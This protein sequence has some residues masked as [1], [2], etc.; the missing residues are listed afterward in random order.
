MPLGFQP[1][2][3]LRSRKTASSRLKTWKRSLRLGLRKNKTLVRFAPRVFKNALAV[4]SFASRGERLY[5][6]CAEGG[7]RSAGGNFLA[8]TG[9]AF[10]AG[11]ADL[12]AN[13]LLQL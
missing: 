3:I 8:A 4:G 6:L 5:L 13:V 2:A 12:V 10:G 1:T 11:D 7:L 9:A